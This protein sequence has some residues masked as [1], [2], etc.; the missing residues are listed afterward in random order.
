LAPAFAGSHSKTRAT[1]IPVNTKRFM[2]CSDS[3]N[4]TGSGA[5]AGR[6]KASPT[7]TLFFVAIQKRRRVRDSPCLWVP[8]LR[9]APLW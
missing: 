3:V 8:V 9:A 7:S 2:P 6:T 5:A 1:H 4:S